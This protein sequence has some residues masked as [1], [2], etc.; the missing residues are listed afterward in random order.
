MKLNHKHQQAMADKCRSQGKMNPSISQGGR[1]LTYGMAFDS[2]L[3]SEMLAFTNEP[4]VSRSRD[5]TQE[6]KGSI[7]LILMPAPALGIEVG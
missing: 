3:R 5:E 1:I 6:G 7:F 4:T 2:M